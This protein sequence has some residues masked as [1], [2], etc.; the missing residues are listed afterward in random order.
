MNNG[1]FESKQNIVEQNSKIK[2]LN[3]VKNSDTN[4][5]TNK[6]MQNSIDNFW[7]DFVKKYFMK[8]KKFLML[9]H[10]HLTQKYQ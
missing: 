4:L 10:I 6:V 8:P 7:E 9:S 3:H 5:S 1:Y 2:Y